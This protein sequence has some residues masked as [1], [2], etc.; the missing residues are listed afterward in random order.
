[1]SD[2]PHDS[3]SVDD[4]ERKTAGV[5]DAYSVSEGQASSP[6]PE[7]DR[8]L[9]LHRKFEGEGKKKLLRKRMILKTHSKAG[10]DELTL[11]QL[12]GASS[13]R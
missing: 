13:Q 8:Y 4:A 11:L 5:S 7:Y 2:K 1:M 6:N 3:S 12:I 10:T 9:D